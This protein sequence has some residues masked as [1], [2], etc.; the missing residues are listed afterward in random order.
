MGTESNNWEFTPSMEQAMKEILPDAAPC[1]KRALNKIILAVKRGDSPVPIAK[2][3]L[4]KPGTEER[5]CCM[6]A[7]YIGQYCQ[8]QGADML[9]D[10]LSD[11]GNPR[12]ARNACRDAILS[13]DSTYSLPAV[14]AHYSKFQSRM[15]DINEGRRPDAGEGRSKRSSLASAADSL[16]QMQ[17]LMKEINSRKG[18]GV[19]SENG[20]RTVTGSKASSVQIKNTV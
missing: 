15:T 5:T 4:L 8:T 10:V 7:Q 18:N 19:V 9:L 16:C 11:S 1:M 12:A 20:Q 6:L 2:D 17:L 14:D 13:M 3:Y